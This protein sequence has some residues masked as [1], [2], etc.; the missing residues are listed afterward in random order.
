MYFLDDRRG[1]VAAT[2]LD[3]NVQIPRSS[4]EANQVA[5]AQS[6]RRFRFRRLHPE[7]C[8]LL[9]ERARFYEIR[10]QGRKSEGTRI[11]S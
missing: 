5:L 11:R 7:C 6:V 2:L 8:P 4:A 9:R 1:N 10:R 3:E